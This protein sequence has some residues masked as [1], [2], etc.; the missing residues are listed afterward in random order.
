M[1]SIEKKVTALIEEPIINLGAE[2]V[3][4]QWVKQ[5]RN[6]QLRIFID[7]ENG[8]NL[9]ICQQVSRKVK[10][11]IDASDI[12]YDNLEVSSPGLDRV[13]KKDKDFKRFIGS[14][15]KIKMVKEYDGPT[16]LIG[17][18]A[19]FDDH[20]IEIETEEKRTELPRHMVS[21]VRLH[22]EF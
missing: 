17:L 19:G 12:S 20:N 13:L 1:V 4:V 21:T 18:L 9:D 3:D 11:I 5:N 2:L 22:P 7:T 15:V 14:R 10:S 16:K 8:V 6:Q